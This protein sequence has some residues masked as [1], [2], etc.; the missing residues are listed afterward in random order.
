MCQHVC[1]QRQGDPVYFTQFIPTTR[2]VRHNELAVFEKK[3]EESVALPVFIAGIK[4]TFQ[5]PI[6]CPYVGVA[7]YHK[8]SIAIVELTIQLCIRFYHQ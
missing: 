5:K 8:K 1:L 6:T 4:L 7:T 2:N 3:I